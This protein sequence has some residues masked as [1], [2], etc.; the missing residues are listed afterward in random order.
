MGHPGGEVVDLI[1]GFHQAA[2]K[3]REGKGRS[4]FGGMGKLGMGSLDDAA[5]ILGIDS[6]TLYRKRKKLGL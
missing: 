1:E 4:L 2:S 5:A 6:S 3:A